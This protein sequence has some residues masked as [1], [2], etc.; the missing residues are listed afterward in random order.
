M[1]L[2]EPNSKTHMEEQ[3]A[4]RKDDFKE[5]KAKR[6]DDFKEEQRR[7]EDLPYQATRHHKE[8]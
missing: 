3:K 2:M 5:E 1:F 4:K 8:I 7:R 6:R